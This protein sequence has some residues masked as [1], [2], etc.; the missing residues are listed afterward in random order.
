ML[1]TKR[2]KYIA[3]SEG[4][5]REQLFDMQTDPG[6]MNNLA[7]NPAFAQVLHEYRMRLA[8]QMAETGDTFPVPDVMYGE[9]EL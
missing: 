4:R 5:L 1:R 7:I 3:Y 2:Y 8:E 6:E 9:D